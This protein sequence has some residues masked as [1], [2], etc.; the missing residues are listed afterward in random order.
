M[1]ITTYMLT[2][3]M[4]T[5]PI[6]DIYETS[7]NGNKLTLLKDSEVSKNFQKLAL[8]DQKYQTISGF[9]GAFTESS[10]HFKS[11]ERF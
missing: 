11:N 7:K 10:A 2:S 6:I 1:L 8:F 5:Q 3:F 9:G 4:S